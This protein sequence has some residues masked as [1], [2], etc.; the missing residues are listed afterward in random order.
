MSR[1]KKI[2][3]VK[4]AIV[5]FGLIVFFVSVTGLGRFVYNSVKDRY[6]SSKKFYFE[7]NLLTPNGNITP[8]LYENWDGLGLFEIDINMLSKNNNL[9]KY[10]GVLKYSVILEYDDTEILCSINPN[11]FKESTGGPV[12]DY[13]TNGTGF[14]KRKIIP[15][16]NEDKFTL[17][18]KPS[19]AKELEINDEYTIKVKAYTSE[20]YKK[21]LEGTFKIKV[22]DVAFY[23]DDEPNSP[24]VILNLRNTRTY[25]SD[26]TIDFKTNSV[27]V[28]MTNETFLN[29][30]SLIMSETEDDL[31]ES[32]TITMPKESSRNIKFYKKDPSDPMLANNYVQWLDI[33]E[34][35]REN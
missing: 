1:R 31:V 2:N 32:F 18:I 33:F 3:K 21:T 11:D 15:A 13:Y 5:I 30:K 4:V 14:D 20:P 23:V 10:D 8:H 16:S 9:E 28:D 12:T 7:S 29:K 34:I 19:G 26:I 6:L 17:Y 24:Y 22:N 25:D 27:R 35:K